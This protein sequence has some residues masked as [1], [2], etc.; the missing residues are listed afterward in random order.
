MKLVHQLRA[1]D[2][3]SVARVG[4]PAL[5]VDV[6]TLTLP[7][8]GELQRILIGHDNSCVGADW[9]LN[10]VRACLGY[11]WLSAAQCW[12]WLCC[13]QPWRVAAQLWNYIHTVE[14]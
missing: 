12:E 1:A 4:G 11:L 9:H 14:Q 6:F 2:V 13:Q 3:S 7:N 10:M 8:V 5:Q